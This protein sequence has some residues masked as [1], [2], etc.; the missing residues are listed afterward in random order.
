MIKDGKYYGESLEMKLFRINMI[1]A[2]ILGLPAQV[3]NAPDR[4]ED[5]PDSDQ[6]QNGGERER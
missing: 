3:K 4:G 5:D 1:I 2:G 6:E